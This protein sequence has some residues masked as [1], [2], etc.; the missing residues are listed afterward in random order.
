MTE[1]I[2]KNTPQICQHPAVRQIVLGK[3]QPDNDVLKKFVKRLNDI[4][5]RPEQNVKENLSDHSQKR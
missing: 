2:T 1:W 3:G 4:Q 5:A